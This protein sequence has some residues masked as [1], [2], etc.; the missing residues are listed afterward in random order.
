M[1]DAS[2]VAMHRNIVALNNV[3]AALLRHG[4]AKAAQTAFHQ[5]ILLMRS[6]C[7]NDTEQQNQATTTTPASPLPG[8]AKHYLAQADRALSKC[9]GKRRERSFLPVQV[10]HYEIDGDNE[11]EN[12][13]LLEQQQQDVGQTL[14]CV[15]RMQVQDDSDFGAFLCDDGPTSERIS[16]ILLHNFG[17]ALVCQASAAAKNTTSTTT[18]S[19]TTRPEEATMVAQGGLRMMRTAEQQLFLM[20]EHC[21]GPPEEILPKD[22]VEYAAWLRLRLVFLHNLMPL[23]HQQEGGQD[24]Q[25]ASFAMDWMIDFLYPS[26]IETEDSDGSA[27]NDDSIMMMMVSTEE[28]DED[29]YLSMEQEDEEENSLCLGGG[30]TTVEHRPA[31]PAVPIDFEPLDGD[32]APALITDDDDWV[33]ATAA[34]SFLFSSSPTLTTIGRPRPWT[35]IATTAGA[36]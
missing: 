4:Q 35:F 18:S 15:I 7:N 19:T 21:Y 28:Y 26:V 27:G 20:V 1:Q 33:A 14:P 23:Y 8:K 12:L 31:T 17:L 9:T 30:H 29:D 6:L 25:Q 2:F 10:Y 5:A 16:L 32:S 24:L 36:A 11:Q 34:S 3:G 13:A 22:Q